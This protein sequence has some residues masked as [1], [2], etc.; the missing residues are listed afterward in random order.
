MRKVM[1]W[2]EVVD[3]R[4][5]MVHGGGMVRERKAVEA[6]PRWVRHRLGG[7][8]VTIAEDGVVDGRRDWVDL[9]GIVRG[10]RE[11]RTAKA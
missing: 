6:C 4:E 1:V 2:H 10:V 9:G 8:S 3:G 11:S 7:L 5:D